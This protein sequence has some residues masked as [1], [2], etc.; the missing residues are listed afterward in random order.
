MADEEHPKDYSAL[1]SDD[2]PR[3]L[4]GL[5]IQ[6]TSETLDLSRLHQDFA[7]LKTDH[8]QHHHQHQ[9]HQSTK[10]YQKPSIQL[11]GARS[12]KVPEA[13]LTVEFRAAAAKLQNHSRNNHRAYAMDTL[14]KHYSSVFNSRRKG[15]DQVARN[16]A[17]LKA[18]IQYS[19][20]KETYVVR[21]DKATLRSVRDKLPKRGNYR[22][23]FKQLD[24]TCEEI[25][26]DE[27]IVPVHSKGDSKY[28]YCQV[29]PF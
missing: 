1:Y 16:G 11:D 14:S 3:P 18:F 23:F 7:N 24:N 29:F 19:D 10:A 15:S 20:Q 8:H 5:L 17:S 9:H 28:I 27:S 6:A 26:R 22:F 12:V 2:S 13:D 4:Q 25:E 21:V